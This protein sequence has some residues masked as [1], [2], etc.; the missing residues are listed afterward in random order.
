MELA[1]SLSTMGA[2]R[3]AEVDLSW[4]SPQRIASVVV[5]PSCTERPSAP[6]R[7]RGSAVVAVPETA[8]VVAHRGRG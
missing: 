6:R 7:G 1:A 2:E 5:A 4:A 3:D 8:T